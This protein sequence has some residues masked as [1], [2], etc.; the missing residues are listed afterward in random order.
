MGNCEVSDALMT[1][2]NRAQ[3]AKNGQ[4]SAKMVH[5]PVQ[6]WCCTFLGMLFASDGRDFA[7]VN[8]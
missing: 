5:S 2:M 6:N 7:G 8:I 1:S 4:A 3:K